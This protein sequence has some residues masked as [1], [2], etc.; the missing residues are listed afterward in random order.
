MNKY[1]QTHR[2][3]SMLSIVAFLLGFI[4]LLRLAFFDAVWFDETYSLTLCKLPFRDLVSTAAL[5]VHPPLYYLVLRVV[6]LLT[7]GSVIACRLFSVL[8]LI[9]TA[10]LGLGCIRRDFGPRVGLLFVCI[11]L[12]L[13]YTIAMALQIRMYSWCLFSVTLCFVYALRIVRSEYVGRASWVVFMLSSLSAAYLHYF[14]TLSAFFINAW[15]LLHIARLGWPREQLRCFVLSSLMQILAYMPWLVAAAGQTARVAGGF[16][17]SLSVRS[18][19]QALLYPVLSLWTAQGADSLFGVHGMRGMEGLYASQSDG[20]LSLLAIVTVVFIVSLLI[21]FTVRAWRHCRL[22]RHGFALYAAVALFSLL[23]SLLFTPILYHRY[24]FCAFGPCALSLALAIS[25][26]MSNQETDEVDAG[27]R[28]AAT[29]RW[30]GKR[31]MRLDV[32]LT[33]AVLALSAVF[34][35]PALAYSLNSPDNLSL[36]VEADK[37][38]RRGGTLLTDDPTCMG[39]LAWECKTAPVVMKDVWG[40]AAS[41]Q[42]YARDG[43][44]MVSAQQWDKMDLSGCYTVVLRIPGLDDAMFRQRAVKKSQPLAK[45][46]LAGR[47][48]EVE[49][50]DAVYVPYE[51]AWYALVDVKVE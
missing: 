48:C 4:L 1:G 16:W 42:A 17:I 32:L 26:A 47:I 45:R 44:E 49:D 34:G 36:Q 25:E 5:D 28:V 3:C 46:L 33:V 10:A 11:I 39:V 50:A 35:I 15:V 20:Q 41:Y 22:C 2:R 12:F 21:C 19:L 6:M 23:F 30:F 40:N 13:P 38:V 9:A 8:G 29:R 51:N 24:L 37:R 27:H 18:V 31:G 43:L 14:G 7:G